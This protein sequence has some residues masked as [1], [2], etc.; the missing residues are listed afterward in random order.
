MQSFLCL[1][2]FRKHLHNQRYAYLDASNEHVS[3]QCTLRCNTSA[4]ARLSSTPSMLVVCNFMHT[5]KTCSPVAQPPTCTRSSSARVQAI[6]VCALNARARAA[7]RNISVRS[8]DARSRAK[9]AYYTHT[10]TQT[11]INPR[12]LCATS[13]EFSFSCDSVV[14][15]SERSATICGDVVIV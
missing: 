1:M 3:P 7:V 15:W 13:T 2:F 6:R 5:Y 12:R 14:V 9:P 10:R 8:A 11:D 4:C